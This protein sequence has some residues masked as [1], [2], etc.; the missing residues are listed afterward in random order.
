MIPELFGKIRIIA[1]FKIIIKPV[2]LR[3]EQFG[4]I[5]A[6]ISVGHIIGNCFS[7]CLQFNYHT[8]GIASVGTEISVHRDG[9]NL[10][11]S[12]FL[13][14]LKADK[15]RRQRPHPAACI[16]EGKMAFQ[17]FH[18][19][20]LLEFIFFSFRIYFF[21]FPPFFCGEVVFRRRQL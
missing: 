9:F 13:Q 11:K 10:Q 5:D 8:V 20:T 16:V 15:Y 14:D 7:V 12:F 19:I 6:L 21:A 2:Q 18:K 3:I 4:N 17:F 1:R